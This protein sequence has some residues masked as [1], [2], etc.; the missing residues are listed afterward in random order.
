[1]KLRTNS[2]K[3]C[4]ANIFIT[5]LTKEDDI[6][7]TNLYNFFFMNYKIKTT[8]RRQLFTNIEPNLVRLFGRNFFIR[9]G[10]IHEAGI[11]CHVFVYYAMIH[12]LIS[13][14]CIFFFKSCIRETP[15]LSTNA[16]SKTD[17]TLRGYVSCLIYS[18]FLNIIFFFG[19]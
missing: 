9:R 5:M 18:K 8:S 7:S 1:M 10:D 11:T 2:L 12:C 3:L 4:G 19:L 14:F 13:P 17:T 6:R 15:T 16:D